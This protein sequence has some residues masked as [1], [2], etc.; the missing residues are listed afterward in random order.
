MS[1]LRRNMGLALISATMLVMSSLTIAESM[2]KNQGDA[3]L[4][5]LREIKQLLAKPQQAVPTPPMAQAKPETLTIKE[6]A[7]YV[8]GKSDAPLTMVEFTDFECPFCKR[9]HETTFPALK[10]SYIDTGKLKFISRNMPLPM[11]P[12]RVES[13]TGFKLRRRS[14]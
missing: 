13:S 14:R 4:Q 1:C 5:E 12:P 3:I 9:F 11:H 10:K 6:D 2:T 8:L 7:I